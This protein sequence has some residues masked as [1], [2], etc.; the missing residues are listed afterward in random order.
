M[1]GGDLFFLLV[2]EQAKVPP[3]SDRQV[4]NCSPTRNDLEPA[5]HF[6]ASSGLEKSVNICRIFFISLHRRH[7]V[8]LL[9]WRLSDQPD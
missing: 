8:E 7:P 4:M 2:P 1:G 9:D 5:P 3:D 6:A